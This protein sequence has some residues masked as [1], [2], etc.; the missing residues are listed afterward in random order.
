MAV[1]GDDFM[2]DFGEESQGSKYPAPL[3]AEPGGD[4]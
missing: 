2:L 3:F 1:Y 4:S